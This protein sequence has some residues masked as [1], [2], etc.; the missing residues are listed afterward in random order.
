[1]HAWDRDAWRALEA[2][3]VGRI[4]LTCTGPHTARVCS[5]PASAQQSR[6]ASRAGEPKNVRCVP[7]PTPPRCPPPR[8][9]TRTRSNEHRVARTSLGRCSAFLGHSGACPQQVGTEPER[10][11]LGRNPHCGEE[12]FVVVFPPIFPPLKRFARKHRRAQASSQLPG[13]SPLRA[14]VGWRS[15]FGIGA[16]RM[17]L[18]KGAPL[19]VAETQQQCRHPHP[20]KSAHYM[21]NKC[22]PPD[23]PWHRTW[24]HARQL[25]EKARGG[26]CVAISCRL[27]EKLTNLTNF[28]PHQTDVGNIWPTLA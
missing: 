11:L 20:Q 1:M 18:Y 28:G 9:R 24:K 10:T 17:S 12:L 5:D 23:G 26:I 27:S 16:G 8:T 6:T 2:T 15:D 4:H 25:L 7:R 22:C 21:L 13:S 14:H 3:F 19:F